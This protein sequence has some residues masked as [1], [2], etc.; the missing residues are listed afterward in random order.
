MHVHLASPTDPP[1]T[2]GAE[3]TLFVAN[4]VTT[5]RSMRGYPTIWSCAIALP[6]VSYL[7]R[8]SS[9]LGLPRRRCSYIAE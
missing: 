4:G 6:L 9:Q 5:I 8:R 1:G 2:A 3:L 7:D